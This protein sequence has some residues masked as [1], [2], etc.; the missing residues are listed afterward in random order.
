VKGSVEGYP[1]SLAQ[2]IQNLIMNAYFHAFDHERGGSVW[3]NITEEKGGLMLVIRDDGYGMSKQTKTQI[4]DPFFTTKVNT[5]GTGLGMAIVHNLVEQLMAGSISCESEV[6][7]GTIFT[8]YLPKSLD[9]QGS[10]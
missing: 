8:V 9:A 6:G 3:V 7:K 2:V 1:G 10:V 4:F 5:V